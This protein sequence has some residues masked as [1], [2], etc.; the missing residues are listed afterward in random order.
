[1]S[2]PSKDSGHARR[3]IVTLV[4]T[5]AAAA[6]TAG[7]A[8]QRR[9]HAEA[10]VQ[11]ADAAPTLAPGTAAATA[12]PVVTRREQWRDPWKRPAPLSTSTS[13][14]ASSDGAIT[15]S[16]PSLPMAADALKGSTGIPAEP[17]STF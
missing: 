9:P 10:V 13:N 14:H 3:V 2:T 5:T 6:V 8:L 12:A 7:V 1:M 11:A 15:P 17:E 4:I 16:D